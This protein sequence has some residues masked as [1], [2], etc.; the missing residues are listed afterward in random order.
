MSTVRLKTPFNL[1][2]FE[3]DYERGFPPT[4]TDASEYQSIDEVIVRCLRGLPIKTSNIKPTYDIPDITSCQAEPESI[5]E[6]YSSAMEDP[7]FDIADIQSI[8]DNLNLNKPDV[9]ENMNITSECES[10]LEGSEKAVVNSQAADS[11]VANS[12]GR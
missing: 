2:Q 1:E 11:S 8:K 5:I 9:V 6:E 4:L 12:S 3:K 7:D 10:L